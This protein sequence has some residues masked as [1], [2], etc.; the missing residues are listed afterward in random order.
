MHR[1][2]AAHDIEGQFSPP[3]RFFLELFFILGHFI[4]LMNVSDDELALWAKKKST[5]QFT[6]KFVY[7][8]LS[9]L[10]SNTIE[11]TVNTSCYSV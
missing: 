10:N 2:Q 7:W 5:V 11:L 3:S 4:F 9:S 6:F 1:P 8:V